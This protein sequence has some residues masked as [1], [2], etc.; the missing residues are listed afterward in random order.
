MF[1]YKGKKVVISGDTLVTEEL[2][3]YSE[4]ADYL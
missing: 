1:E 2:A 3:H 4:S